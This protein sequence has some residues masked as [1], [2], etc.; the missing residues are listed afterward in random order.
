MQ[1]KRI[2]SR[3]D[4]DSRQGMNQKVRQYNEPGLLCHQGVPDETE[5]WL[6]AVLGRA[7]GLNVAKTVAKLEIQKAY[8]FYAFVF[9]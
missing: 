7:R 2:S 4:R 8:L 3:K 5:G 6:P 9:A 1:H